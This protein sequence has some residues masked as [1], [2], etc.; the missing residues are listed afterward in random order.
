M[1]HR[2]VGQ[3]GLKIS[4]VGLGTASIAGLYRACS[5]SDAMDVLETAW[6]SGIRYF[7]TAPFYGFGLAERRLGDYLRE[8]PASE[9]VLSTKVGRVLEPTKDAVPSF[10]F[11]DAL[12]FKFHYDYGYDGIMRSIEQSFARLGLSKIDIAYVHD[13][14]SFTHGGD[15]T[16]LHLRQLLDGGLRALEELKTAGVIKGYGLGVNEIDICNAVMDHARLDYILLAGRYTLLDRTAQVGFLPRCQAAGTS[17]VVG[18][19]FNSGILATGPVAD[20][21]FDYAPASPEI[22]N[23][24]SAMQ[25][26]AFA[27]NRSLAEAAL[28]FPLN[29]PAVRGILI[30]TA[31]GDSLIRNLEL[32]SNRMA[33]DEFE[34]FEDHTIKQSLTGDAAGLFNVD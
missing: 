21:Y 27:A 2:D 7:D 16:D 31:K 28:Q 22:L 9:W 11:V 15:L 4:E 30:G 34:P 10:G 24:V 1:E 23:K 18:G 14:G 29:H 13:I 8:K 17:V 5:R 3:T 12:P 32:L 20:A 26:L 33:R 6:R 25:D 19:V